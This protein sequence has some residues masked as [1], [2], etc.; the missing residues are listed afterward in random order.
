MMMKKLI[1]MIPA[2]LVL[3]LIFSCDREPVPP[4]EPVVERISVSELRKMFEKGIATIDTNVYIRG[5]ITLT[6]ELG[7]I[8][9]FIAYLQDSTAGICLT[10]SGEN[11]FAQDSE[12]KIL[13][14]GA[15][16]TLYNGLL[17]FG[18]ISI[19]DQTELIRLTAPP[20]APVSVTIDELLSGKH[21]AEY[22]KVENVQFKD[23]GSFSGSKT[24]TDCNSQI[25]VYTRP[26]ATF[27]SGQLPAGNGTLRGVASVYG[28][29]QILLRDNEELDMI[30]ER[31]GLSG[32]TYLS[33]NF[34]NLAKYADV[35]ALAG[36]K[37]Y[38]EA[39]GK[40]WYG[41]EVSSRKWVQATAYNSG[42]PLV[43]AWMIL[44]VFDLSRAEKPFI[45]FESANGY[46][47]GATMELCVSTNY[48]GSATPWT[49]TWTKL[50]FT[51]PASTAS[52]YSQF[53]SSGEVDL[54]PF[55]AEQVTIAWV[56][57]GADPSGSS[58]DKTTTWEVDNVVVGER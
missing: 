8:P 43:I 41:N 26:D 14:R 58:S 29:V 50:T 4:P 21:Q 17:Q 51:L 24:L 33:E 45:S 13:C 49:S 53:V 55:K 54:S 19:T 22:V 15:S 42:Q 7:N 34:S 11:T 9:S 46:D 47:N 32:V 57:R 36:W 56:Y 5:I 38:A 2:L 44:P 28:D 48:N 30:G 39:G 1:G 16:F 10:V 52:G 20:P 18:D 6:P 25:V 12:V 3:L 23:P 37:T 40:T 27:A 35:S 31:C